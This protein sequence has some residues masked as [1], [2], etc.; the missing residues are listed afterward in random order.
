ML[1]TDFYM[2]N[3]A[4][5]NVLFCSSCAW[6]V[7]NSAQC[8][9]NLIA[10]NYFKNTLTGSNGSFYN[11]WKLLSFLEQLM[12]LLVLNLLQN[13]YFKNA[14]D[15]PSVIITW[16]NKHLPI[17]VKRQRWLKSFSVIPEGKLHKLFF[18]SKYL[19]NKCILS[20]KP[21]LLT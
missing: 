14:R 6:L 8:L 16:V 17:K 13:F 12:F 4:Y 3:L 20:F 11:F 15:L 9:P 7:M 18:K 1:V 10:Y 2:T 5:Q 19:G 21:W